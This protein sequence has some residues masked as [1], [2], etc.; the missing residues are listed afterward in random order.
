MER[1]DCNFD[2]VQQRLTHDGFITHNEYSRLIPAHQILPHITG[3]GTLKPPLLFPGGPLWFCYPAFLVPATNSIDQPIYSRSLPSQPN[4]AIYRVLT[5]NRVPAR[6][7]AFGNASET[8]CF[9]RCELPIVTAIISTGIPNG[10]R[11]NDREPTPGCR[12]NY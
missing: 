5:E 2:Q 8:E 11:N 3:D 7:A 10:D 1:S 9:S 12:E 6:I 4:K